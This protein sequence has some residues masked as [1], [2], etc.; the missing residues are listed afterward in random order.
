MLRLAWRLVIAS[1]AFPF[2][3]APAFAVAFLSVIPFGNLLL[4]LSL[5]ARL[6][7]PSPQKSAKIE[8]SRPAQ[9]S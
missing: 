9:Q 4:P 6:L 3:V 1:R 8:T 2:V 5:V 7:Q